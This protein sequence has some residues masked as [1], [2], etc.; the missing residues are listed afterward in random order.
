MKKFGTFKGVFV[1]SFEA[2]LGT[3]LFLLLPALTVDVGLLPM[4]MV[5]VLSHTVTFATAFSIAD[6]ATNLNQVGGGGA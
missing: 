5:I 2:I 6:C 1:P 4:I 3:V